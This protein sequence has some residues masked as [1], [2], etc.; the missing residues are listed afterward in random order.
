[1]PPAS[2]LQQLGVARWLRPLPAAG[3]PHRPPGAGRGRRRGRTSRHQ[4]ADVNDVVDRFREVGD[5]SARGTSSGPHAARPRRR[6]PTSRGPPRSSASSSGTCTPSAVPSPGSRRRSP[7]CWASRPPR[8][9]P[10][11]SWPSRPRSGCWCDR[12]GSLR[13]GIPRAVP[14]AAARGRRPA[15]AARLPLRAPLDRPRPADASTTSTGSGPAW[16]PCS[17][18]CRCATPAACCPSGTTWSRSPT[19]ARELGVAVHVDGARIWESQPFYDR[20]LDEIAGARRQR[21]RVVLQ[22][23]RRAGRRVPG[24]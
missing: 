15:A 13:V 14:P 5:G 3:R 17:S 2:R 16:P 23:P 1:M 4:D 10:A 20:P 8:C 18:S 21:L 22:G 9:S 7:S 11:G 6:W 12:A 24:R 19:R